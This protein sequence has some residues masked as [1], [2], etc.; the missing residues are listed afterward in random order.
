MK[1]MR[2]LLITLRDNS[3]AT[4]AEKK[5]IDDYLNKV[6]NL[7]R[8]YSELDSKYPLIIDEHTSPED[9]I[10]TLNKKYKDNKF[11]SM[12]G[13]LASMVNDRDEI[14]AI[15]AKYEPSLRTNP[16]YNQARTTFNPNV[17]PDDPGRGTQSRDLATF[18]IM[19]AQ[20]LPRLSMVIRTLKEKLESF[21]KDEPDYHF[22]PPF[23][24]TKAVQDL[25]DL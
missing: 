5:K 4:P 17:S 18:T 15:C 11:Y 3:K 21:K 12:M 20:N 23:V 14:N 6:Q 24:P 25:I 10:S 1:H 16:I 2:N 19:P 8:I 13:Q 7:L 9:V 22:S